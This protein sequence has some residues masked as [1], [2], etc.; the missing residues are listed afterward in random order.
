MS[1]DAILAHVEDR[2][3][4]GGHSLRFDRKYWKIGCS[5]P[6][7]EWSGDATAR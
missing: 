3:I 1:L 2:T 7:R 6:R 4:V 5:V